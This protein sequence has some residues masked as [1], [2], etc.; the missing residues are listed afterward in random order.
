MVLGTVDV[1]GGATITVFETAD[2]V[3]LIATI[4]MTAADY[5]ILDA[6]NFAVFI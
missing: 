3:N 4:S 5:A 1:N 2:V 6:D